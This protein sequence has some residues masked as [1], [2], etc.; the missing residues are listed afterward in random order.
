MYLSTEI[1]ENPNKLCVI[2]SW[3][4]DSRRYSQSW[5]EKH[6]TGSENSVGPTHS[7][8]F[9]IILWWHKQS[10]ISCDIFVSA[11]IRCDYA[12]VYLD[13]FEWIEIWRAEN[14]RRAS[15]IISH[16]THIP[17]H[18]QSIPTDRRN[19]KKNEKKKNQSQILMNTTQNGTYLCGDCVLAIKFWT[20]MD[21]YGLKEEEKTHTVEPQRRAQWPW[22]WILLLFCHFGK[23]LLASMPSTIPHHTHT[24]TRTRRHLTH[25]KTTLLWYK[26][27][28]SLFIAVIV[29]LWS[30]EENNY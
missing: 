30:F 16:F 5:I 17:S 1:F 19:D 21:K 15:L 23:L 12:E 11:W 27:F 29:I 22:K 28:S 9:W 4:G 6:R 10:W 24:Q 18:I 8:F 25:L 2:K 3:F 20:E 7:T 26:L 13:E 14:E